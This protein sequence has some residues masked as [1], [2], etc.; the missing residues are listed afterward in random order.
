MR[1]VVTAVLYLGLTLG[2]NA[3]APRDI[4]ALED[5]REGHLSALTFHDQPAV[6]PELPF[7]TP[8]GG[9]KTLAAYEG[10]Y[11]VLNFWATW[12]APCLRELP[13]LEALNKAFNSSEFAVVTL[14]TG[15]NAPQAIDRVF[16]DKDIQ[17][18][19]RYRDED[20]VIGKAFDVRGLPVTLILDPQGRE[21]ARMKGEAEWDSPSALAIVQALLDAH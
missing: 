7:T 10:R 6:L 14:A 19:T 21:I 4:A 20:M 9:E 15:R 2:A 3:E 17:T 18:L 13:S 12:C 11:V 1:L 8:E 16:A 5:L